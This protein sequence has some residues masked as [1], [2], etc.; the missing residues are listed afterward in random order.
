MTIDTTSFRLRIKHLAGVI[1]VR[2][3]LDFLTGRAIVTCIV[4]WI[5]CML[6]MFLVT[7]LILGAEALF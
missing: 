4:G 7:T 1:A 2:Q 5:I 3:A 6:I